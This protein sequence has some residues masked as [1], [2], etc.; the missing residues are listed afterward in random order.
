MSHTQTHLTALGAKNELPAKHERF[1]WDLKETYAFEPRVVYDI[2]ACVLHW[3]NRARLVWPEAEFVLFDAFEPAAFLYTGYKHHVGVLSDTDGRC[4]TFHQNNIH[5]TGNSY[6]R[7]IGGPP[8]I[9]WTPLP[10]TTRRLDSVAEDRV[11]PLPDLVKL[12]VQG[13]EL[14][15]LRGA[16]RILDHARVLIVEMQHT[17]YNEGAPKVQDTKPWIEALGFRCIAERFSDN[18]VDADYAFMRVSD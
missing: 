3:T 10:K 5:P 8:T 9:E 2:G 6:Y 12:D 14:D 18:G 4:V 13:S 15:I 17:D 11:F 7:E 16:P 1:L